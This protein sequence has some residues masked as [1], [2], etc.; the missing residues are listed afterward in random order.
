MTKPIRILLIEDNETNVARIQDLLNS[1]GEDAC[2]IDRAGDFDDGL[3]NLSDGSYDVCLANLRAG[4]GDGLQFVRKVVD[5]R[6]QVPVIMLADARDG[7]V[8]ITAMAVGAADFLFQEELSTATLVRSIRH[9]LARDRYFGDARDQWKVQGSHED[10]TELCKAANEFADTTSHKFRTPLAVIKAFAKILADGVA[11]DLNADQKEY[12]DTIL[13]RV[14]D[15]NTMINDMF[16]TSTL[17]AGVISAARNNRTPLMPEAPAVPP[18]AGR[19]PGAMASAAGSAPKKVEAP[20][21]SRKTVLIADDDEL[22]IQALTTIIE[23]LGL[24]VI[25]A[26]DG[27]DAL[28][29]FASHTCDLLILDIKMPG[30]DGLSVYE[31]ILD[32]QFSEFILTPAILLTGKSDN[33]SIERCAEL[34]AHYVLKDA[35]AWDK[36]TVLVCEILQ[37]PQEPGVAAE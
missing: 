18:A 28:T 36:L 31:K 33:A 26:T 30:F 35:D 23:G 15:L 6:Y 12:L 2:T 16:E 37:I 27:R 32:L 29:K 25:A 8:D 22:I 7:K 19:K 5:R 17:E 14:D 13:V 9:A 11:G 1:V 4:G 3:Q 24:N 20:V 21:P 34:H 10:L